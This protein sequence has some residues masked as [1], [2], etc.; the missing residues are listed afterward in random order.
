[1]KKV[2]WLWLAGIGLLWGGVCDQRLFSFSTASLGGSV[3]LRQV[4]ENLVQECRMTVVFSEQE[5]RSKLERKLELVN[6]EDYTLEELFEYLFTQH[7]LFYEYA[8]ASS[9]LKIYFLHTR[10]FNVDYINLSELKTESIKA[11]TVGAATQSNTDNGNY[12]GGSYGGGSTISTDPGSATSMQGNANGINT[13]FTSIKSVSEF[14][15][16]DNLKTH[17]DAMLQRDEDA[18]QVNSKALVNREAGMV[19]VTGTRR[20][21]DRV[22]VYIEKLQERMHKQV[23]LEARLIEIT[24]QDSNTTGVDWS[25]FQLS[26]NGQVSNQATRQNGI[27]TNA[28]FYSFG[29]DFS[30]E[31]LLNFLRYYG[32]VEILSS[33]KVMTLNNQAAVINVGDQLNYRFQNGTITTTTTGSP[34]GTNTY[35]IGSVFVGLTLNIVPELTDDGY[36]IL[37]IN[38]VSSELL[39]DSF[40]LDQNSTAD[41]TTSIREIPPDVKVKQLTSIVKVKDGQ[42]VLVGGLVQKKDYSVDT[43]VPLLGDIPLL[44]RLFHS[45]GVETTRSELFVLI[46]PVLVKRDEFPTIDEEA[47][48]KRINP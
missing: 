42:K 5:A 27:F 8:P 21:V 43:K 38:P 44:G 39:D 12:G 20:Q 46:T 35:S 41:T 33:P 31:G 11:I 15:F 36:I 24:Y 10:T 1:M 9:L 6:I 23:M 48:L 32:N 34:V 26:L 4:V 19:T 37:R 29:F 22:A 47:M 40:G 30:T 17:I 3:T 25:K 28:P 7:N 18:H 2:I 14:K 13:D 16:W 45:T